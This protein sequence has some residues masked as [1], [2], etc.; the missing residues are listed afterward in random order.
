[1]N[2]A[3]GLGYLALLPE[4]ATCPTAVGQVLSAAC[5]PG[6]AL[7]QSQGGEGEVGA[8]I[9]TRVHQSEFGTRS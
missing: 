7:L 9:T 3:F 5:S 1:M 6:A 8:E 2:T 4:F